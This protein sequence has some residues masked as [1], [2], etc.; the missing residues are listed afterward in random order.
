MVVP[1]KKPGKET[2]LPTSC[3][4]ISL[5]SSISKILEKIIHSHV[6]YHLDSNQIIP[7]EQFGFR[8]AHSTNHQLACVLTDV[9][10]SFNKRQNTALTLVDMQ[11]AFDG[12]WTDALVHKLIRCQLPSPLIELLRSYLFKRHFV[13]KVNKHRTGEVPILAEEVPISHSV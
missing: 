3:R 7:D 9:T 1:M 4:S 2:Q 13:V 6:L 8:W 5:L 12:V 11:K 10:K